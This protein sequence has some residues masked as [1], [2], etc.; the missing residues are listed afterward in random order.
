MGGSLI[1]VC[2]ALSKELRG[3]DPLFLC[4]SLCIK[5][6]ASRGEE[7]RFGGAKRCISADLRPKR[8][9]NEFRDL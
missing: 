6:F 8:D 7:G 3:L 4:P 2:C 9:S 5:R 1:V